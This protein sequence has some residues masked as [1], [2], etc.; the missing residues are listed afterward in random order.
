MSNLLPAPKTAYKYA[1]FVTQSTVFA[2]IKPQGNASA[3]TVSKATNLSFLELERR[4]YMLITN[5]LEVY[6]SESHSHTIL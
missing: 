2:R 5:R 4:G 1:N 3:S 6:V